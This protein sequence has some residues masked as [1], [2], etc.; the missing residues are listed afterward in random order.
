MHVRASGRRATERPPRDDQRGSGAMLAVFLLGTLF[1][2]ISTG[3]LLVQISQ[4]GLKQQLRYHGQAV[5][6]AQAG[7]V[8][9]LAWFR[10][11]TTQPVATF[12]PQR[13][14]T[15][16][17][18]VNETDDPTIGIVREYVVD[19]NGLV[20]GRY[21]VPIS[22]V[23]DVTTNRAKS[24]TGTVWALESRGYI[25]VRSDPSKRFDQPP[26]RVISRAVA[27]SE[28][29]RLSIVLPANAAINAYRG[30]AVS[31]QTRTRVYGDNDIGIAYPASTGTPST[32]GELQGS[33]TRSQVDPYNDS[34]SA[35]FGVT[36][37]ELVAMADIVVNSTSELPAK[38]PDMALIVI[39]GNATFNAARR[40][41]GTG[42]LVVFGNLLVEANSYSN[43]N[44]LIYVTGTY[45]Q[46]APSQVSGSIISQGAVSIRGTG[47]FSEVFYDEAV[48]D[49]IKRHMGQY[50]FNRNQQISA[51]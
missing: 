26:N 21:E 5:N 2:L 13:D 33:P 40:M 31:T 43:Y 34:L 29:Q 46:N 16:T 28:I 50:R 17:P 39:N 8:D 37:S 48:L 20:W 15:A 19:A 35:V 38:L 24:G 36:Q 27:R 42:V 1:I 30:D 12:A 6:A 49:Q 22:G 9:G 47:D 51:R 14:L 45:T 11:Q 4:S 44:G 10:R 18:P 7:L 23:V 41:T 3:L 25:Y 32:S